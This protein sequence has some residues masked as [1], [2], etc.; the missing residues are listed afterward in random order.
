MRIRWV[1]A[2]AMSVC[3]WRLG[4]QTTVNLSRDVRIQSGSNL[5]GSCTTGQLFLKTDAPQGANVYLC[6]SGVWTAVGV[7]PLNGD[8]TGTPLAVTVGGIQG[9]SISNQAPADQSVLRWNAATSKWEPAAVA[10]ALTPGSGITISGSTL[11]V[12]D[13]VVPI[14]YTGAGAPTINCMTGRDFYIDSSSGSLYFCK[15]TNQ[16]Q[17]VSMPG[18]T[19]DAT[20]VATGTLSAA[21]LPA[22]VPLTGQTNVF[23]S[24]RR[25]SFGHDST[26]A[27]LRLVPA[28]GDPASAQ[29][30]DVWYNS[31]TGKFRLQQN[32]AALDWE[33]SFNSTSHNLLSPTHGDTAPGT[34]T[35]GDLITGQGSPALWTRLALG[36]AG[37]YLRSNGTDLTYAPIP[38]GDLPAGYLW[39]SLA[40]VPAS[41]TPSS[42][43]GTHRN[44]GSDEIAVSAPAANAI[45]K[46]GSS[47]TLAAGWLPSPGASTLGGVQSKDC[48]GVGHVLRINADGSVTCSADTGGSGGGGSGSSLLDHAG[49]QSETA[50]STN[51]DNAIYTYTI[52]GG[53][54]PAGKCVQFTIVFAHTTGAASLT[55]EFYWGTTLMGGGSWAST[56]TAKTLYEFRVCNRAGSTGAQDMYLKSWVNAAFVPTSSAVT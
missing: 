44:G 20:E 37:A 6:E 28:P 22:T 36:A 2:A 53:A 25:Q 18:H 34:V 3:A 15:G 35:K 12:E 31:S 33:A 23:G 27:G 46:A 39:S 19:H 52:L 51:T 29:D 9:R 43:A 13:S 32:G 8:A 49:V 7:P 5:P 56:S 16:W 21:R 41:F 14:Y 38:L 55:P 24:G 50:L 26:S 4:G 47:G 17:A 42:H 1:A 11:A 45:P 10:V 40:N 30:G 48:T 54:I